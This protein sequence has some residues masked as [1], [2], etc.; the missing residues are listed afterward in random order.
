MHVIK[1]ISQRYDYGARQYDPAAPR[2]T[3]PDPLTEKYYGWNMYDY[4]MNNPLNMF[5]T[6]DKESISINR[7]IRIL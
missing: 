4:C 1:V 6:F 5:V 3:T 7:I 2:F